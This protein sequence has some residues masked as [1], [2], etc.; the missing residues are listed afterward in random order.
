[1]DALKENYFTQ[2]IFAST[3]GADGL[4]ELW[5]MAYYV[6]RPNTVGKK[7]F[8]KLSP[9]CD[10]ETEATMFLTLEEP[11]TP[12]IRV[13]NPHR[14]QKAEALRQTESTS[15]LG[16]DEYVVLDGSFNAEEKL[17]TKCQAQNGTFAHN[18]V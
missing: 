8:F 12:S 16:N 2:Q 18:G 15:I 14:G 17:V 9:T 11:E 10:L 6:S 7:V 4:R 3:N 13:L 5:N 1:M